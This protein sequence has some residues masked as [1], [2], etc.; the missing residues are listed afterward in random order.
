[1]DLVS[2]L[3]VVVVVGILRCCIVVRLGTVAG[4]SVM[5]YCLGSG[6][7]DVSRR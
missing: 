3:V 4:G 5:I 7:L 1:L 6:S 2:G